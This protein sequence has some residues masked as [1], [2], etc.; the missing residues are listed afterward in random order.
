MNVEQEDGGDAE[1]K[2][3]ELCGSLGIGSFASFGDQK[4]ISGYLAF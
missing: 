3:E 2:K 1:D 4:K